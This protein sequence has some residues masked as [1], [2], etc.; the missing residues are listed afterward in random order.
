MKS[1][2]ETLE[3]FMEAWKNNDWNWMWKSSQKTWRS[4]EENNAERLYD[5]FGHKALLEYEIMG[6]NEVSECCTDVSVEI[7]YLIGQ[8]PTIQ[9]G[10]IEARLL[11]EVKEYHPSIDGEWGVNPISMLKEH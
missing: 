8:Q 1:A 9:T 4:K 3:N 7:K 2:V 11:K 6:M 5:F 10:L